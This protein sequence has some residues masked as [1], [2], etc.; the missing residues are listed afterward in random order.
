M[1][2]LKLTA[3][4]ARHHF[5][6]L[7]KADKLDAIAF[8]DGLS[9]SGYVSSADACDVFLEFIHHWITVIAGTSVFP[10]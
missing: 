5:G 1:S 3:P 9:M 8:L 2:R 6:P 4:V 7:S 10:R